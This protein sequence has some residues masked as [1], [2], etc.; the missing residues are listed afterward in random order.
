MSGSARS[1]CRGFGWRPL[2]WTTC[3]ARSR[4]DT[5]PTL[6]SGSGPCS[7]AVA[8]SQS[9]RC[10]RQSQ[11]RRPR[12][13]PVDDV[14]QQRRRRE[15]RERRRG[16]RADRAEPD[17]HQKRG[18]EHP[19]GDAPADAESKQSAGRFRRNSPTPNSWATGV[20]A[21]RRAAAGLGVVRGAPATGLRRRASL[22]SSRDSCAHDGAA[23]DTAEN[24]GV[25]VA[26]TDIVRRSFVDVTA[27]EIVSREQKSRR[28]CSARATSPQEL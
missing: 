7:G 1:S 24:T 18:E 8:M 22:W 5:E 6:T 28:G 17:W 10:G 19:C 14:P 2:S 20:R 25:P 23:G 11:R 9:P 26:G 16:R 15:V 13:R 4:G 27:D 3:S 21:A 12:G